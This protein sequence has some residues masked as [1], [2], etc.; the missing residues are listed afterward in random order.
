MVKQTWGM[1]VLVLAMASPALAQL[2]PPKLRVHAPTEPDDYRGFD[3]LR[4][5]MTQF[6]EASLAKLFASR[7]TINMGFDYHLW[8]GF[9]IGVD[10]QTVYRDA[11]AEAYF[12]NIT[13][14]HLKYRA[15]Y[16]IPLTPAVPFV[17][18][19]VGPAIA[20]LLGGNELPS[21]FGVGLTG[22]L[23]VGLMLQDALAVELAVN[24]GGAGGVSYQGLQLKL[25]TSF[26]TLGF[27]QAPQKAAPPDPVR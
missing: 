6:Q 23:G 10:T 18:A 21:T 2:E 26:G 11:G 19:G 17:T 8:K 24:M 16:G 15:G 1:V 13:P 14:V 27:Y 20:G 4:F 22:T 7:G 9:A 3:N 12:M 5:G 25:G